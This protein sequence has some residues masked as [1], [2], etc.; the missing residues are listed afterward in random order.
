MTNS[1]KIIYKRIFHLI[2][3]VEFVALTI[4]GNI[5][6]FLCSGIIYY[7]EHEVNPNLNHFMDAIWWSF[8]T[9]TSVGYGDV[10]P[11][12]IPGKIF[13]ILLMLLGTAMF[14]IYTALFANAVLGDY[15]KRFKGLYKGIT[16][17]EEQISKS[18]VE[19]KN[20]I[21]NLEDKTKK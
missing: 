1:N 21:N 5:L 3:S 4:S 12:T 17:E 19:L 10:V 6:I 20:I 8:S 18:I 2:A 14:A 7:L 13:G 11:I 9:V 15:A 16:T